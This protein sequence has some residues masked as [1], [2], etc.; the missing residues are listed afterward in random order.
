VT[1]ADV[2]ALRHRAAR[3]ATGTFF[4]EGTRFLVSA[5][6]AG[7]TIDTVVV[8]PK[9]LR[10][11]IG[12]MLARRLRMRGVRELRLAPDEFARI[13]MM[14]EPQGVGVVVRQTWT[15]LA[16][17]HDACWIALEEVRSPGNLGTLLRTADATGATGLCV[18]GGRVDPFEPSVVRATMGSIFW[19]RIARTSL[20]EL[21]AFAASTGA[22]IVGAAAGAPRDFREVS[23]RRP[24]ILMLGGERKGLT[25]AQMQA[26]DVLVRI[27]MSGRTDSLNL[28]VA[29]SVLLYEVY[30][31]RHPT[32]KR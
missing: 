27:P 24:V 2:L 1:P 19:R 17:D 25:P 30:A 21:R 7:A 18:L 20:A 10:S 32:H 8:A 15:R 6:D 28:A 11:P 13:S 16:P 31:Q 23:Y 4:A 5:I 9:L 12:Q 29:G 14:P 26:C 3:D 22:V